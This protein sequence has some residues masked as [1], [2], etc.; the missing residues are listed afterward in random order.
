M[1]MLIVLAVSERVK[2]MSVLVVC[3]VMIGYVCS[4]VTEFILLLSKDSY[5]VN[6]HYWSQGSFAGSSWENVKLALLIIVPSMA[7]AM[8]LSKSMRTYQLGEIY[9]ENAGV[10]IRR[11]RILLIL[12]SSLLSASVTALAGPISFVGVAAPHLIRRSFKTNRPA[13]MLPACFLGGAVFTALCDLAAR[14]LLAPQELSISSI[15]ACIGAPVVIL[16]MLG[17]GRRDV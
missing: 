14:T 1:S 10:N 12:L 3:G 5:I 7:A 9:A 15:T 2:S 16:L 8:L 4:A 13:V 11:F 17:K 6:L